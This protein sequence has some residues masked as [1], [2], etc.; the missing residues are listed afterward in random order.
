MKKVLLCALLFVGTAAF[1][2]ASACDDSLCDDREKGKTEAS[3]SLT[4]FGDRGFIPKRTR[5][6]GLTESS[7]PQSLVEKGIRFLFGTSLKKSEN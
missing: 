5:N 2:R 1:T 3:Q 7:Q 6:A 4:W